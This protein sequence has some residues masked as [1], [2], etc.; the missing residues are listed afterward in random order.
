MESKLCA[1]AT[2]SMLLSSAP[3][4]VLAQE[5]ARIYRVRPRRSIC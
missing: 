1:V 2:V 3:V 4:G 5:N